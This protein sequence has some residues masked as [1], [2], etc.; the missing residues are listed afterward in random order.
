MHPGF[1]MYDRIDSNEIEV[2]IEKGICKARYALMNAKDDEN[3]DAQEENEE[4]LLEV[5][6]PTNLVANYSNL[7]V[8]DLPTC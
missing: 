2:E 5:Y 4:N 3:D 7:K 6:N 1:M 8:T